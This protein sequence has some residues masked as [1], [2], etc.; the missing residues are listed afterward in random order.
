MIVLLRYQKCQIL[1]SAERLLLVV[2]D[3]NLGIELKRSTMAVI[4]RYQKY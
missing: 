3:R 2:S 4:V 1:L